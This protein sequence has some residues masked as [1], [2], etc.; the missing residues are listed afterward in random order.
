MPGNVV[1]PIFMITTFSQ[2]ISDSKWHGA[3]SLW[4][5]VVFNTDQIISV[6][7]QNYAL[8]FDRINIELLFLWTFR[9]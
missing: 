3:L 8:A 5:C 6:T 1:S 2:L 4:V 9:Y 7:C